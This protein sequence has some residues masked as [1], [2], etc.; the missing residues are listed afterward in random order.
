MH[1]VPARLTIKHLRN[2]VYQH[3]D[4]AGL[5]DR[6][7]RRYHPFSF[8]FDSTPHDLEDPKD[9][10]PDERKEQHSARRAEM[11]ERLKLEYGTRDIEEVVANMRDLGGKGMSLITYHNQMHEQARRAFVTGAYYP[12][13]VAACALG[14]RILNHLILDLRDFFK[15]S[16]HYKRVY[17]SESFDNWGFAV[18]VLED[19]AVLADG[20]GA[21]F[22]VLAG[23]RNRSVHFDPDTYT[24]MRDDA[25][26]ALLTLGRI[27][28][29]QFG[30]FRWQPWFIAHTPG[31]QFVRRDWEDHP[32]VRTYIIPRS[33][34][35]GLLYGME[36]SADGYW[37]HLDYDDY[38]DGDLSDEQFAKAHRERDP[39]MVVTREMIQASLNAQPAE[40]GLPPEERGCASDGA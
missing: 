14:E 9:E 34:L 32:F 40:A 3:A 1:E 17:R 29:K 30:Y 18:Q 26:E 10:W 23:L 36:L 7:M 4:H 35:V 2:G 8:D 27:I 28:G 5:C 37:R 16:P 39:A 20:V 24:T 25:L 21:G 22:H 38:G 19:W 6:R 11:I 33:G 13:L 31:S 12:A 15:S